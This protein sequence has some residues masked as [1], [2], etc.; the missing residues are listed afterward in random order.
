MIVNTNIAGNTNFKFFLHRITIAIDL[1]KHA[2]VFLVSL[3]KYT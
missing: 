1:K 2:I 3:S